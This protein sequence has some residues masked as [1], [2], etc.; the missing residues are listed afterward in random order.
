MLLRLLLICLPLHAEVVGF[1]DVRNCQT[2][3]GWTADTSRLNQPVSVLVSLPSDEFF[4]EMAA[5]PR[6]DVGAFLKD[7]GLHGFRFSGPFYN[8]TYTVSAGTNVLSGGKFSLTNCGNKPTPTPGP[9]TSPS[10]TFRAGDKFNVGSG[11]YLI[12][13]EDQITMHLDGTTVP[14]F[15]S[16]KKIPC[17]PGSFAREA[18]K[19]YF[20]ADGTWWGVQLV[21]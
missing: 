19:L 18:P 9:G 7:N 14:I 13:V 12:Q 2:I 1:V 15:E 10:L 3:E 8:G 20:C 17:R 4:S 6:P 5:L 16:R 11:F 21:K